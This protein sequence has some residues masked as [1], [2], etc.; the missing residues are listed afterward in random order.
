MVLAR[1]FVFPLDM[2]FDRWDEMEERRLFH[3]F[4]LR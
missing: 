4:N 3:E 2:C 1:V